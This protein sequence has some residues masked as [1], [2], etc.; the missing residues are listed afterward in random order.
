MCSITDV[1]I[2]CNYVILLVGG[3]G[4][5]LKNIVSP[6]HSWEVVLSYLEN[7]NFN[8]KTFIYQINISFMLDKD[9]VSINLHNGSSVPRR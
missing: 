6:L 5:C 4:S 7:I 8:L 9:Q 3:Y 2:H 1:Q